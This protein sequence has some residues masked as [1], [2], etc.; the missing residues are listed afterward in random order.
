M[1]LKSFSKAQSDFR[2]LLL[3]KYLFK[4]QINLRVVLVLG[5]V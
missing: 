4:P 1:A 2:L 3:E 5:V